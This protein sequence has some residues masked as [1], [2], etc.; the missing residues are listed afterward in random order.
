MDTGHASRPHRPRDAVRPRGGLIYDSDLDITWL[1]DGNYAQTSGYTNQ[2]FMNYA[3]ANKWVDGLVY[4]GYDD[5]RLPVFLNPDGSRP[6]NA[7][8]CGQS[9][10]MHLYH[11][12]L[13]ASANQ[14]VYD[15]NAPA[16]ALFSNLEVGTY[17][18]SKRDYAPLPDDAA[19]TLWF[20]GGIETVWSKTYLMHTWAVRDGDSAPAV[21]PVPP[22]LLLFLSSLAAGVVVLRS[23]KRLDGK[24]G[25]VVRA[26]AGRPPG[27]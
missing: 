3:N 24:Q 15:V 9:E 19:W 11:D 7:T 16:L 26:D 12:E 4:Q 13:G 25:P 14:S 1:K 6:C 27:W 23:R 17:Y 21:V 20:G 8:T 5:W 10:L 22:T 2:F 18:W